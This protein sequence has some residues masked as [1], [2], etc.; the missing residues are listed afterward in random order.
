[1]DTS[2]EFV[3]KLIEAERFK[4]YKKDNWGG[5]DVIIVSKKDDSLIKIEKEK[6]LRIVETKHASAIIW[7]IETLKPY[8]KYDYLSKYEYYAKIADFVKENEKLD[9]TNLLLKLLEEIEKSENG[10]K[11]KSLLII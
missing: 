3:N 7:L 6:S 4:D 10:R 9:D 11:L 5:A 8:V 2:F 1:M